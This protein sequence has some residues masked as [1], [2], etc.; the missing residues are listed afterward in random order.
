M[1][2]VLFSLLSLNLM[3]ADKEAETS[4]AYTQPLTVMG[5]G[6]PHTSPASGGASTL[7]LEEGEGVASRS[8]TPLSGG[9]GVDASGEAAGAPAVAASP[10]LEDRVK[11]Y[12]ANLDAVAASITLDE[13]TWKYHPRAEELYGKAKDGDSLAWSKIAR[14]FFC[15][16][17]ESGKRDF[18][19]ALACYYQAYKAAQ[20]HEPW[21]AI[22][23][24]RA[25][26]SGIDHYIIETRPPAEVIDIL[27]EIKQQ[28][29]AR[30]MDA[31]HVDIRKPEPEDPDILYE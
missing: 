8:S 19:K 24:A 30:A 10:S 13:L 23:Y 5:G 7:S 3:A 29:A 16:D 27:E 26:M 9:S 15:G 28:E 12:L 31:F 22:N 6:S 17:F 4:G 20:T 21:E 11:A 14:W 1:R 25:F 2:F 18:A